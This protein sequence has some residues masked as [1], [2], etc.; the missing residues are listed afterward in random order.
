[1]PAAKIDDGPWL[2]DSERILLELGFAAVSVDDRRA[3]TKIFMSNAIR[4][5][6]DARQFWRRFSFVRDDHPVAARKCWNHFWRAFSTFYFFGLIRLGR[7]QI[8]VANA[9]QLVKGFSFLQDRLGAEQ[10][11]FGGNVPNTVDFQLFGLVQMCASIPGESIAVLQH[12]SRL[13]RLRTWIEAMQSRFADYANLYTAAYFEPKRP[14][15]EPAR[16]FER[17]LFWFGAASMWVAFPIS[18]A[19]GAYVKNRIMK[20]RMQQE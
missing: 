16:S 7:R 8:P 4:R 2:L 17:A 3:L 18:L 19:V 11:F 20:K 5:T 10:L 13:E 15:I 12:D 14:L 6:D 1:M 9:D